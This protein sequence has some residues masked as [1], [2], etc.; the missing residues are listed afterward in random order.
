VLTSYNL[1]A[2]LEFSSAVDPVAIQPTYLWQK[3]A[4]TAKGGKS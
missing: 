1:L 2:L 3:V 4:E